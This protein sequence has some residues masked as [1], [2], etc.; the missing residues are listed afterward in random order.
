MPRGSIKR[1]L[2]NNFSAHYLKRPVMD[3]SEAFIEHIQASGLEYNDRYAKPIEWTWTNQKCA[4]GMKNIHS[5]FQTLLMSKDTRGSKGILTG[6]ASGETLW[7]ESR[8][9]HHRR[10]RWH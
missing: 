7:P 8:Q 4:N 2:I 3:Q 10:R 6:E 5:E 9:G 1:E